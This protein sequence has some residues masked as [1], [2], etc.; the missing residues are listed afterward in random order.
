MIFP[1]SIQDNGG[2]VIDLCTDHIPSGSEL[3]FTF[4]KDHGSFAGLFHAASVYIHDIAHCLCAARPDNVFFSF[5]LFL[6]L[7]FDIFC[8]AALLLLFGFGLV[9]IYGLILGFDRIPGLIFRSCLIPGFRFFFIFGSGRI[10]CV[11]SVCGSGRV[12]GFCFADVSD[13]RSL[14]CLFFRVAGHL[15]FA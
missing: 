9:C 2:V 3:S 5:D 7:C 1:I 15:C 8:R 12:S 4:G 10:F 14:C 13:N 6:G 11:F